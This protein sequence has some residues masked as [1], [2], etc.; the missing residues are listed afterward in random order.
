MP[1]LSK[2]LARFQVTWVHMMEHRAENRIE[3]ITFLSGRHKF[4]ILHKNKSTLLRVLYARRFAR[5]D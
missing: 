1:Y 4:C 5:D 3:I 2:E